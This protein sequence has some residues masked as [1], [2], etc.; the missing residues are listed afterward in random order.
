MLTAQQAQTALAL[1]ANNNTITTQ[2]VTQQL[3]SVRGVTFASI[4]QVTDVA[5]VAAA[6]KHNNVQKVTQA[7]IQ[8]FNNVADFNNVYT[9]AVKRS[10]AS[11]AD[12]SAQAVEG[13]KQQDNYFTHTATF[14]LVQHKTQPQ[15][16]YLFAIYNNADSLYFIN[17]VLST[18]QQVATLLQPAAA[19][20]LLGDN[21]IV[22]NVANNIMHTVQVRT[23]A[24]D[25]IVQLKAQKQTL[26]V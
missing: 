6:H 19:T 15:K 17:N 2:Q 11:I 4:L 10:A 8:L 5:G 20:K 26:A 23:I 22:H 18:K 16:H 21:S 7:S 9:A 3:A 14:S 1:R 13:F 25:S 12:N 24:L